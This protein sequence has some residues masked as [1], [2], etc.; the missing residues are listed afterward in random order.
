VGSSIIQRGLHL[1][2]KPSKG[3]TRHHRHFELDGDSVV[4]TFAVGCIILEEDGETQS[5]EPNIKRTEQAVLSGGNRG[6]RGQLEDSS[7]RHSKLL[8]WIT[9]SKVMDTSRHTPFHETRCGVGLH[10]ALLA[11]GSN[12][13]IHHLRQGIIT[14]PFLT[15]ATTKP[16]MT[17]CEE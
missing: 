1:I 12:I 2:V 13:C 15:L 9:L 17:F 3:P 5:G 10:G 6:R 4:A 8:V 14:S 7:V 16:S 11:L